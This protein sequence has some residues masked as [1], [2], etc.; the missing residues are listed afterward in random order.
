MSGAGYVLAV[1]IKGRKLGQIVKKSITIF[2]LAWRNSRCFGF[3]LWDN[4]VQGSH[5]NKTNKQRLLSHLF[6][7]KNRPNGRGV[8]RIAGSYQL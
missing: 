8:I 4:L 1:C 5:K 7:D 2:T 3:R 6:S